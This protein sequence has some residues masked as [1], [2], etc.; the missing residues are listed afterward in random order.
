MFK[1][2]KGKIYDYS[3]YNNVFALHAHGG[4]VDLSK[5]N[6]SK[7]LE[8]NG[9]VKTAKV[10][11]IIP[12]ESDFIYIRNRAVSAGNVIEHADGTYELVPIDEY[13]KNFPKYAPI[14][15]NAN[16]NGDFFSHEELVAKYK[17]FVGKSVFVDHHNENVNDARGI[18]LD[19]VYN[20]NGYFVELLEAID[21]KAFPQLA[22]S[23]EKRYTTDTS[24]GCRCGYG[25]CSICNNEAHSDD[26]VCEHV[27]YYKGMTFNGL[28]V[29]EDN[30]DVEFFED[31][32]VTEG[33]DPDAKILEKVASKH[34]PRSGGTPVR[35]NRQELD[36]A[37]EHNQRGSIGRKLTITEQ[38]NKLQWS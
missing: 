31:S 34:A 4:L 7:T 1:T 32:I 35:G 15:R 28:P 9:R 14:C 3:E 10:V 5:L 26:D 16:A 17:T 23:I 12:R 30:R 21:K 36:L 18:I 38:L 6:E 24:M 8:V 27:L 37:N 22:N 33:A 13:F 29:F 2:S 20:E 25:V 11:K 19:A